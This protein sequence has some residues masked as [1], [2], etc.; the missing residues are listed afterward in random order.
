MLD[1]NKAIDSIT[2]FLQDESKKYLLVMIVML[3]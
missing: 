1:K 3:N 2:N